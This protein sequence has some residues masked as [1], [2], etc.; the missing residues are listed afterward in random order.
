MKS[1]FK[2]EIY[3]PHL[4]LEVGHQDSLVYAFEKWI[5][6]EKG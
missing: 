2:L 6:K 3:F 5:L 1:F 4:M